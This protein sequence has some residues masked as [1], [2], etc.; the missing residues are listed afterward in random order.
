MTIEE[1]VESL[2][3][4]PSLVAEVEKLR[5][6]VYALRRESKPAR[7]FLSLQ[8]AAEE[9]NLCVK[10]VRRL[11]DR[12]LLKSSKGLRCVRIPIEEIE[13]YKRRTV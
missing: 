7:K 1:L 13:N 6:E 5:N 4:V 10:S 8:Q 9:L 11:M 2:K 3:A 12:G